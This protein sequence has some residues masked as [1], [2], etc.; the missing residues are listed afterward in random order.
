[1]NTFHSKTGSNPRKLWDEDRVRNFCK[2]LSEDVYKK[3]TTEFFEKNNRIDILIEAI[4]SEQTEI[5]LKECHSLR[6]ASTMIGLVAFN[7]II[8][9][10]EQSSKNQSLLN[11]NEIIDTL[12]KLIRESKNQ[13]L[14]LT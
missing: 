14:K 2:V 8:D 6:G 10:I 11:K 4:K 5:I 9:T 7:D 12:N 1:M 3:I 13:F